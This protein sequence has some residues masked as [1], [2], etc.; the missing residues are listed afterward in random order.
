MPSKIPK[1]ELLD[2]LRRV[3]QELGSP[4]SEAQYKQRGKYSPSALRRRFGKF[5]EAREAAGI[6]NPDLRG[7]HNKV[8]REE[9]L[10]ALHALADELGR[11]PRRDEMNAQ[12]DYSGSAYR[13]EFGGWNDALRAAGYTPTHEFDIERETYTC[14]SCGCEVRRLP[15]DVEDNEYV[16][17]D[18]DCMGEFK[19]TI[20]GE[21]HH[22][23][24]QVT[25]ECSQCGSALTRKPAVVDERE[26]FFCNYDCYG[27]WCSENRTG[28]NH[29]RFK[30]GGEFYYGPNFQAQR[31]KALERDDYECQ[32]CGQSDGAP[33][34]E[35][36]RELSVHHIKPVREF[37]A[38]AEGSPDWEEL[39]SLDNLVALCQPCHRAIETLPVQP[40]FDT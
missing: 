13:R 25:V 28:E 37:Y 17:C 18:Y 5:T 14:E 39:N 32:R 19:K 30:G 16:F 7:G 12:G 20:S 10:A 34:N 27:Q 8:S 6:P 4:P 26:R 36:N 9:L 33:G 2:D 31:R 29:P 24:N 11:V 23:Y 38:E 15:S 22:Q 35:L 40:R 1:N 21:D 3:H